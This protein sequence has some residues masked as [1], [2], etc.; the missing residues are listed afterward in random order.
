[1]RKTI[2]ESIEWHSVKNKYPITNKLVLAQSND[3]IIRAYWDKEKQKWGTVD[4]GS[5]FGRLLNEDT[6]V[7]YW[8][9]YPKGVE[10][11]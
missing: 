8:S 10:I 6:H 9:Y 7:Y 4:D 2:K 3:G 1:M 11:L 5:A